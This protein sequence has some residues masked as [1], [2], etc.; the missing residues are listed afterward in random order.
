MYK[1][2]NKTDTLATPS[3]AVFTAEQI[4]QQYR[5]VDIPDSKWIINTGVIS[6]G[7]FMEF[8]ATKD[9][10]R[11]QG[12]KFTDDM[13]DQQV[14][15]AISAWEENPPKAAPSAEERMAAAMEFANILNMPEVII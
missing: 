8:E 4:R 9:C 12:V 6:M 13:T 2:W 5:A 10:Y 3:G 15:D 7:V 1:L 14:L 11:R